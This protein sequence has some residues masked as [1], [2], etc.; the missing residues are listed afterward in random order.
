MSKKLD[1]DRPLALEGDS[2]AEVTY[3]GELDLGLVHQFLVRHQGSLYEVMACDENGEQYKAGARI[4]N[5]ARTFTRYLN[6]YADGRVYSHKT[7][8]AADRAQGD[9]RLACV[10][11]EGTEGQFDD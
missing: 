2:T 6:F 3:L 11:V 7:K 8:D 9:R 10:R 4:V 1:F 5:I